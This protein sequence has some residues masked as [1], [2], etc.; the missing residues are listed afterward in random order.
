MVPG[1]PGN[2][3][4]HTNN[5]LIAALSNKPLAQ[6]PTWATSK[7]TFRCEGWAMS[8]YP[9]LPGCSRGFLYFRIDWPASR[10][11]NGHQIAPGIQAK[12]GFPCV[13]RCRHISPRG[14]GSPVINP[15]ASRRSRI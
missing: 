15:A 6:P 12:D 8:G 7:S 1:C 4:S 3:R 13:R 9:A 11:K 5:Y 14:L 2:D 10:R